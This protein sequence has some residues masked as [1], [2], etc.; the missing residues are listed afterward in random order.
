MNIS[1]ATW[2]SILL[3][4]V[5]AL[6]VVGAYA[7]YASTGV[8]ASQRYGDDMLIL[9]KH[10]QELLFGLVLMVGLVLVPPNFLRKAALPMLVAAELL[11][12]AV[13]IP[14]IGQKYNGAQ[15]WFSFFGTSFQPSEFAKIA[16][17]AFIAAWLIGKK[18]ADLERFW[19]TAAV[20]LGAI[21][22][23]ALL[24]AGE[25]NMS[26]ALFIVILGTILML[27]GGV[28]LRHI[29]KAY[30][31]MLAV[32]LLA[33]GLIALVGKGDSLTK[34]FGYIGKRVNTYFSPSGGDDSQG[35]SAGAYQLDE[36]LMS[37]AVGGAT[38]VGPG[39]GLQQLGYLPMSDSDFIF[40]IIGQELGFLGSAVVV[41]LFALFVLSGLKIAVGSSDRF[42]SL[43]CFGVV[44]GIG[45]QSVIHIAVVS[46]VIPTTGIALPFISRGGSAM[47]M[48]LAS[49][50]IVLSAA[51]VEAQ[52]SLTR[53]KRVVARSVA[54]R[55]RREVAERDFARRES[56]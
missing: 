41:C 52:N 34:K 26:T 8:R 4:V 44:S 12:I 24:I 54:P 30:G 14:G 18:H 29:A 10:L 47:L 37:L 3:G 15:R 32:A 31:V 36:S 49:V 39:G 6:L 42:S 16:L 55:R 7:I 20:P 9:R 23:T 40:A 38:G 27:G 19:P 1:S 51:R 53:E 43:L 46:G 56:V 17:V 33:V 21:L 25:P 28:R 50:G 48:S 45:L 22:F 13:L 35:A 2:R 11:L 5:F